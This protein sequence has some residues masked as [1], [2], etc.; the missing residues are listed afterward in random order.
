MTAEQYLSQLQALLPIGVA[1]PRGADATLTKVLRAWADELGRIDARAD[2]LLNEADPLTTAELLTD[3]ERVT[4]L[5][6]SCVTVEQTTAQ[7]RD[8]LVAKLTSVGGQ[9]PAYFISLAATLGY[10]ISIT[11]YKPF[12]VRSTVNTPIRDAE[13]RFA[14]TVGS[15]LDT[16]RRFNVRSG[17]N[18]PL[19]AWGNTSLECMINRFKPAHTVVLFAY[20]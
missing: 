15:A 14:F 1:W 10:T 7:R 4:A 13:W 8:A 17:V 6:D 16:V 19:A 12:T 3:W 9:T 2:Q 5:P 11:E 20:V 18:E